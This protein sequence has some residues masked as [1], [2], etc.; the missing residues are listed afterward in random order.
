ACCT[1]R[2]PFRAGSAVAV[3]RR[4]CDEAPRPIREVNPDIPDWLAALVAKLHAKAPEDRF[5]SAAEAADLLGR[6]PAHLP[7]PHLAP[8]P[9]AV[10]TAAPAR[11][12]RTTLPLAAAALLLVALGGPCAYLLLRPGEQGVL[13][14]GD[15]GA[16][17]ARGPRPFVP[18]PPLTLEE[19]A[20]LP[21]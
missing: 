9:R 19:L 4:V 10:E 21:S 13:P 16:N 17:Q 5:Q 1:G 18:R 20:R 11:P 2:P 14:P 15:G 3:L 8:R 7:Q 6:H 12:R